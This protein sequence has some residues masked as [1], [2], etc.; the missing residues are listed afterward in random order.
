[1]SVLDISTV[2][3]I[4]VVYWASS[5]ILRITESTFSYLHLLSL[6]KMDRY[7]TLDRMH[8]FLWISL[9]MTCSSS[10]K[11]GSDA[12]GDVFYGCHGRFL[13]SCCYLPSVYAADYSDVLPYWTFRYYFFFIPEIMIITNEMRMVAST[14]I[15]IMSC[16][17]CTLLLLLSVEE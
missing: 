10:V 7:H 4:G 2:V 11:N 1:M 12:L 8:P 17:L 16:R 5:H 9:S 14:V 15:R 13:C 3:S 6:E